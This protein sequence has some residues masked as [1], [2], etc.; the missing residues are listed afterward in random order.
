[1]F[2]PLNVVEF[3]M[4]DVPKRKL[5]RTRSAPVLPTYYYSGVQPEGYSSPETDYKNLSTV[6]SDET[7]RRQ[8]QIDKYDD[9]IDDIIDR[10]SR[11][12]MCNLQ[13]QVIPQ[14]PYIDMNSYKWNNMQVFSDYT[15]I[16]Y[17][18]KGA[19][20]CSFRRSNSRLL[21]RGQMSRLCVRRST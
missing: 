1:M 9:L 6:S 2:H 18:P 20:N 17:D 13:R 14:D 16:I 11:P 10:V 19:I 8:A 15:S 5:V 7:I 4:P 12:T 21:R 3:R